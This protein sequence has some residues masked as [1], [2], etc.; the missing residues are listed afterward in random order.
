MTQEQWKPILGYEGL[1]E[2]STFGNIRTVA[3]TLINSVGKTYYLESQVRKPTIINKGCTNYLRLA[4]SKDGKPTKFFVHRLVAETFIPNPQNKSQVNHLDYNGE[5]NNVINLEWCTPSENELHSRKDGRNS[6]KSSN[7]GRES[8]AAA[9]KR[10]LEKATELVGN[11][12]GYW[13]LDSVGEYTTKY[14]VQNTPYYPLQV[15]LTCTRCNNSHVRTF[16][17]DLL[18]GKTV[19]CTECSYKHR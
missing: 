5:N 16:N 17:S 2:V 1:Y 18:N 8:A 10:K 14:T 12:F 13:R 3:R 7:A 6:K 15:N 9:R 11:M 19:Q 4:L